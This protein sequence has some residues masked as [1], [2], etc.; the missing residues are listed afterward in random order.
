MKGEIMSINV[1]S[2]G[3]PKQPVRDVTVTAHGI[4]GDG[5]RDVDHHGGVERALCIFALERIEALVAEG[6]SIAP[7]SLGENLTV[8]GLDWDRVVPGGLFRIGEA[9][10]IE[11]TQ[12]TTPCR[13]ISA[14]FVGRNSARVSQKHRPGWSRVYARVLVAGTI[15]VGARVSG[16]GLTAE[17]PPTR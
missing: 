6:H 8:Q 15:R 10:V 14:G 9:V 1:S 12:Y 7:G 17:T 11:I 3:V 13:N 2:G 16:L 4:D 5:H